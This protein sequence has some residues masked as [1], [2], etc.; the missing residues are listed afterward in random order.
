MGY[1]V[2]I[3]VEYS[4]P[5]YQGHPITYGISKGLKAVLSQYELFRDKH[6]TDQLASTIGNGDTM[7]EVC[8]YPTQNIKNNNKYFTINKI[9]NM[10]DIYFHRKHEPGRDKGSPVVT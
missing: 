1:N 7:H 2:R 6:T 4:E 5:I 10:T 9:L 8:M 3:I